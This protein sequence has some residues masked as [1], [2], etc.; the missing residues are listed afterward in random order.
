MN[1]PIAYQIALYFN[2]YSHNGFCA[3]L[4]KA[5]EKRLPEIDW[6][7]VNPVQKNAIREAAEARSQEFIE[8]EWRNYRVPPLL[9]TFAQ[10]LLPSVS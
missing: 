8:T 7:S 5:I 1:S 4:F 3:P 9:R 10:K 2:C 6:A